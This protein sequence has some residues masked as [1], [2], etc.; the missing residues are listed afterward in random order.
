MPPRRQQNAGRF[1]NISIVVDQENFAHCESIRSYS[2]DEAIVW[3]LDASFAPLTPRQPVE[4][5]RGW[6]S[7]SREQKLRAEAAGRSRAV[8]GS[9]S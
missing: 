2:N 5:G 8:L 1:T 4:I 6:V 3:P 7:R 9:R